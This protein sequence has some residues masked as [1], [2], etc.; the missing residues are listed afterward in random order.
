MTGAH[1]ARH[2]ASG[3]V[4]SELEGDDGRPARTGGDGTP[5]I[6]FLYNVPR[7]RKRQT[8]RPQG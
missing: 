4:P 1:T 7:D 3:Q 8:F 5:T 2:K 6:A